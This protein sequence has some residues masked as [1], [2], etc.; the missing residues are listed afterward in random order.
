MRSRQRRQT[1]RLLS[2]ARKQAPWQRTSLMRSRRVKNMRNTALWATF[3]AVAVLVFSQTLPGA[4]AKVASPS[5]DNARFLND[6]SDFM[7]TGPTRIDL[8]EH[9]CGQVASVTRRARRTHSGVHAFFL[10]TVAPGRTVRIVSDLDRMNAPSW[11]WIKSGDQVEVSGRYYFD[12]ARSQGIDWTHHGT[13]RHWPSSG[14][15]T[16]NGTRYE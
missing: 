9:V 8:P 12:S 7:Q 2:K 4:Q 3:A 13:G 1:Q 10:L 5:C 6:Q 14:Y 15:V 11:P 16:V